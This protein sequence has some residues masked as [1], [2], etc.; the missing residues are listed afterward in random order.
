MAHSYNRWYPC[1]PLS[2]PCKVYIR[3][4][5]E[6]RRMIWSFHCSSKYTF[7]MLGQTGALRTDLAKTHFATTSMLVTVQQWQDDFKQFSNWTNLNQ[8]LAQAAYFE[9]YIASI[10]RL[11]FDSDP[12]LIVG[13]SH[14]IDG[15]RQLKFGAVIDNKITEMHLI[16]CTKG[17]WQSRISA[18]HG[19]FGHTFDSLM[20]YCGDLE[21]LREIRNDVGHAFGRS[22][23]S[24]QNYGSPS[25]Q[26]MTKVSEK[27]VTKYF[28]IINEIVREM[29]L[30]LMMNHIGNY[31]EFHYLH[32][33]YAKS[34]L[35]D[36]NT[37]KTDLTAHAHEVYSLQFCKWVISYYC[38]L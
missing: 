32:N 3:H 11:V 36:E 34:A 31:Q 9:T 19:L 35:P 28:R 23:S 4:R 38:R 6:H 25:I 1:R 24:S 13:A 2:W 17:T 12:G 16:N 20:N 5:E 26:P 27:M 22:I 21:K 7:K 8:L 33:K 30:Y 29:D 37:Y 10:L 15:V 14:H 18:I